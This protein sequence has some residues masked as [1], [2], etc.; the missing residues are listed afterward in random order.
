MG[1]QHSIIC[2]AGPTASGKS[3]RAIELAQ[4]LDGEVISVDSRQVYRGLDIGTE[5]ISLEEMQGVPHHL[6]DICD[7]ATP[8]NAA[9]FARDAEKL[10]EDMVARGK[11]PILAGGTHFYFETLIYG[12]PDTEGANPLYRAELESFST[13][14]LAQMLTKLDPRRASTIDLLNRRRLIRALEIVKVHGHVPEREPRMPRYNVTWE[15]INPERDVLRERINAR[16]ASAFDRGLIEEVT[17]VREEVGDARLT[18]LG[19]EYRIV[20]EYLRGERDK[21]TLIPALESKLWHY[22]RHQRSWLRRLVP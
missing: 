4:E 6:I 11:V 18:E 17:R 9:D 12:L 20:G 3:A 19:L 15:I 10:I 2:V 8:Y 21:E 16:L 5:K 22:A 13:E 7:A 14:E 1:I